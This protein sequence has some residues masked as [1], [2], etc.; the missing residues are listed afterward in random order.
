M[1]LKSVHRPLVASWLRVALI[2][3]LA[4]CSDKELATEVRWN[5][6]IG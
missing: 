6:A 3:R 1:F 5:H 2:Y 4:S